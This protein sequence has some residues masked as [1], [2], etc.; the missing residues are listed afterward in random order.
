[1]KA[2]KVYFISRE[3]IGMHR[4]LLHS[5]EAHESFPLENSCQR[6]Q[7]EEVLKGIVP[8]E[9]ERIQPLA[10]SD[11]AFDPVIAP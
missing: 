1:V 2:S 9:A 4:D 11:F 6:K 10:V 8:R 3:F 7:K 5:E